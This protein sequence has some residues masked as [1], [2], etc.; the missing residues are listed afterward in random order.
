MDPRDSRGCTLCTG[1]HTYIDIHSGGEA[2]ILRLQSSSSL[3]PAAAEWNTYS[4]R[5][6]RQL[7]CPE[8]RVGGRLDKGGRYCGID[9]AGYAGSRP[10]TNVPP[11]PSSTHP[12]TFR[13]LGPALRGEKKLF[14]SISPALL[15][16]RCF[17]GCCG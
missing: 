6:L 4:G 2:R 14:A 12:E 5:E 10:G 8:I 11:A 7:A 3:S 13:G 17:R 9:F 16:R 1:T 15:F